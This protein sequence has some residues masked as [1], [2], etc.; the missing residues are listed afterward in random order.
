[1]KRNYKINITKT[2]IQEALCGKLCALLLVTVGSLYSMEKDLKTSFAQEFV[3]NARTLN[4]KPQARLENEIRTRLCSASPLSLLDLN[5]NYETGL[6]YREL[7]ETF[8][9][10]KQKFSLHEIE[11]LRIEQ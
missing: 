11:L 5:F 6:T 7:V 2:I 10:T 3:K 1:M 4:L 8:D 9:A